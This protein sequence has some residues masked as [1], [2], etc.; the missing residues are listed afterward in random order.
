MVS[1]LTLAVNFEHEDEKGR[2]EARRSSKKKISGG[3]GTL[4]SSSICGTGMKQ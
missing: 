1:V 4:G 2:L 3:G